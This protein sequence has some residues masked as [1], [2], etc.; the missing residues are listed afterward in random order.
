MCG[1]ASSS[2][3]LAT[4]GRLIFRASTVCRRRRR[5]HFTAVSGGVWGP[6]QPAG[7]RINAFHIIFGAGDCTTRSG[8][9]TRHFLCIPSHHRIHRVSCSAE[10]ASLP[11][12]RVSQAALPRLRPCRRLQLPERPVHRVRLPGGPHPAADSECP[13]QHDAVLQLPVDAVAAGREALAGG[14]ATHHRVGDAWRRPRHL[15]VARVLQHRG[16]LRRQRR[17][18]G[19]V[20]ARYDGV[21][22][23]DSGSGDSAV[24]CCVVSRGSRPLRTRHAFK[25]RCVRIPAVVCR[26]G[27]CLCACASQAPPSVRCTTC[28]KR[29]GRTGWTRRC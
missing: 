13:G 5:A 25:L 15:P 23:V 12:V 7:F 2:A 22:V 26:C 3:V 4:S 17:V 11:S 29:G 19:A 16:P 21:G 20:S 24:V 27:C 9:A 10:L 6:R 14:L 1:T 18:V 8:P 28:C